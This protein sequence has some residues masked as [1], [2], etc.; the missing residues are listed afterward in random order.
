MNVSKIRL[1]TNGI[2]EDIGDDLRHE[3]VEEEVQAI[4]FKDGQSFWRGTSPHVPA[5]TRRLVIRPGLS[6][7]ASHGNH[8][9]SFGVVT[10][11][12][13]TGW[14]DVVLDVA[15]DRTEKDIQGVLRH[16]LIATTTDVYMQVIPE[17]V[18]KT[19]DS[20]LIQVLACER[21]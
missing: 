9:N 6:T 3:P 7:F 1:V 8:Y 4:G 17:S 20:L 16:S 15:L 11:E 18:Q 10:T 2:Y 14:F 12:T 5:N 13:S 21:S 19:V